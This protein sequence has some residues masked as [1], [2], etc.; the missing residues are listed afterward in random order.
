M[1]K[2]PNKETKDTRKAALTVFRK[3]GKKKII[4][5]KVIG[6]IHHLLT[7][8]MQGRERGASTSNDHA[9]DAT[10]N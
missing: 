7:H 2:C 8:Y 6:R 4:P 1:L 9:L 3:E 10:T 5:Q